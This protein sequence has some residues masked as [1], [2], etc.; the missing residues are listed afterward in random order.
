M[1]SSASLDILFLC[2]YFYPEHI[3]SATL[4]FDTAKYLAKEGYGV[5]ALCGYPKEYSDKFDVDKK[6]NIDNIKI[7]RLKYI[8]LSRSNFFGRLV[9]YF[10][11]TFKVLINIKKF[12]KYKTVIV[13]SNPPILPLVTIIAKKLYGTKIIFVSYDVYPEIAYAS[14]SIRPGSILDKIMR[15]INIH[16]YKNV[17]KVIAMTD[18]MK[19][20]I[21]NNREYIKVD[22][23][24]PI[25]NWAHEN[26]EIVCDKQLELFE[27]LEDDFVVSYFGNL[28]ICQEINTMLKSAKLL[29]N[30]K[31]I[32]FLIIGHGRKKADV[33]KYINDNMLENIQVYD[34]MVGDDFKKAVRRSSCFVV[35]LEDGLTGLCAPS[36]YYSYLQG[37]KPIFAIVPKQSYLAEEV[38]QERIGKYIAIGDAE[39]L[40]NEIIAL[41]TD[42][43]EIVAIYERCKKIYAERYAK[44][45]AMQK[46]NKIFKELIL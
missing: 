40:A 30:N 6:E 8:Q 21:S 45:V 31:N 1:R 18:E 28:G 4:P 23:I 32:K 43:V 2:Q 39:R 9:N 34:Y 35:S 11:F 29:S 3:S 46:Y 5:G 16:L 44:S 15:Y 17:D 24:V 14:N 42:S 37:G 10:S 13:Y 36:K 33:L 38:E 41:S 7:E 27:Y 25:H 22:D 26:N 20:F 12:K 19:D